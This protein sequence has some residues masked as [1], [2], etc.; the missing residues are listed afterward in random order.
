MSN[1]YISHSGGKDS[2][3]MYLHICS[4]ATPA[5]T[6]TVVHAD[7]GT[8]EWNGTQA[9]IRATV[10]HPLNVVSAIWADGSPKYLLDMVQRRGMFPS[11]AQR[12]CTSDL[13][14]GPIEKFIRHDMKRRG[15]TTAVNCMGL[16][17]QESPARAKKPTRQLNARLSKA[18][19]TVEDW[20][21]IHDWDVSQ[22]FDT[23]AA[24]GQKPHYAYALGNER[25]SCVFCIFGSPNDLR[26][27][28]A[29]RPELAA[30]YIELEARTGKTMFHTASLAER[31]A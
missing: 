12:Y 22:V 29:Q 9:H 14:R 4:I 15:I 23:I 19:R 25:L 11:S 21:P 17:A 8:V 2:Q 31:I 5:D 24:A 20:L 28:A 3:A 10:H 1:Y 6:I 16:R 7:L 27:G 18:G 26:N 30:A 13:K